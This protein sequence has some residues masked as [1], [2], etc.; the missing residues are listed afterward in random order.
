[1]DKEIIVPPH[2]G[3][4]GAIG[5]A[6]LALDKSKF[7]SAPSTFRGWSVDSVDYTLREFTCKAC[8]NFCDMQ[9]FIVEDERTY[10]GDK[11]SHQF[12]KRPKV[13]SVPIIPDLCEQRQPGVDHEQALVP[14]QWTQVA[15]E[16]QVCF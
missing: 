6:L 1:M 12:R 14:G 4:M 3:V 16:I 7:R 8:S 13:D 2:N 5:V 9:E 10:W 11:C 15:L